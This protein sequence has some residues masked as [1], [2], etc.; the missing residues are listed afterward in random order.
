M[1]LNWLLAISIKFNVISIEI[2]YKT[3]TFEKRMILLL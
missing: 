2:N 1:A 3:T